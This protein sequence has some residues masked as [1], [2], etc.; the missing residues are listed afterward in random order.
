MRGRRSKLCDVLLAS[1]IMIGAAAGMHV[2]VYWVQGTYQATVGNRREAVLL[3]FS[4]NGEPFLSRIS[5]SRSLGAYIY[6][7]LD[8]IP[9]TIHPQDELRMAMD[10]PARRPTA[11]STQPMPWSERIVGFA[12]DRNPV[13]YWYLVHDGQS[14]GHAYFEGF[15]GATKRRVGYIGTAGFREDAVPPA[16]QFPIRGGVNWNLNQIASEYSHY[17]TSIEPPYVPQITG[18]H[19]FGGS[20]VFLNGETTL[21]EVDLASRLVREPLSQTAA[22][23]R[24]IALGSDSKSECLGVR[25]DTAVHILEPDGR[26]TFLPLAPELRE[27]NIEIVQRDPTGFTVAAL[28]ST[29]LDSGIYHVRVY[30]AADDGKLSAPKDVDVVRFGDPDSFARFAPE[31]PL[32]LGSPAV[33]LGGL[34]GIRA[35]DLERLSAAPTWQAA[36]AM[37]LREYAGYL[38]ATVIAGLALAIACYRRQARYAVAGRARWLWPLFV[39]LFGL[40]GWLGYR[41][42][43]KWPVLEPCPACHKPAPR[44]DN[45]CVRCGQAF[46]APAL[47]GTEIFA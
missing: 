22:P 20:L 27:R 7:D 28:M 24:S 38:A 2:V 36:A 45:S 19:Q 47:L 3:N 44:N 25:T 13:D 10:L 40:P 14:A 35:F 30:S 18:E 41:Y 43:R 29:D 37:A 5:L 26:Q 4:A 46:P 33:M 31:T 39:F 8:G 1:A 15:S 34:L 42:R 9:I 21:Y 6:S 32:L 23:I 17:R 16:E 12:D 11:N